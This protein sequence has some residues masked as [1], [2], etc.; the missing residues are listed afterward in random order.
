LGPLF[1]N[2]KIHFHLI[3]ARAKVLAE[4]A[5][6]FALR[7]HKPEVGSVQTSEALD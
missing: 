7:Q 3:Q 1:A 2:K 4:I 6:V 5:G